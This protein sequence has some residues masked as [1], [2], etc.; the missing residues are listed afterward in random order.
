MTTYTKKLSKL[1]AMLEFATAECD[2]AWEAMLETQP[3]TE[4]RK[5]ANRAYQRLN[6]ERGSIK[7][8][9]RDLQG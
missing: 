2:A 7:I 3:R 9:I 1:Q 5:Y 8:A 4:A 6:R